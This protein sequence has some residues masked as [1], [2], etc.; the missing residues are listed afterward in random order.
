VSKRGKEQREGNNERKKNKG[1]KCDES[2]EK[3]A[4]QNEHHRT[5]EG[6]KEVVVRRMTRKHQSHRETSI[7]KTVAKT[8]R[9]GFTHDK[10][11]RGTEEVDL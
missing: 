6:R 1:K 8:A 3:F 9:S 10:G 5:K 2:L 7:A 11:K 4:K